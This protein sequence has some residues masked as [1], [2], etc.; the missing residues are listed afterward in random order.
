MKP[1]K[2]A[3]F[4][5]LAVLVVWGVEQGIGNF[6]Q[7]SLI[8][9]LAIFLGAAQGCVALVAAAELC[10]GKWAVPLKKHLLKAVP[11]I[12]MCAILY[13]LIIPQ[14][15]TLYPEAVTNGKSKWF[16]G[17]A[18]CVGR[19]F[20][21]M[22]ISFVFAALYSKYTL[23]G[24]SL[25]S[26][27]FAVLYLFSYVICQTFYALD[28]V[29]PL[30][31]P[32]FSTLFGA[33]FFVEGLYLGLVISACLCYGMFKQHNDKVPADVE[34]SQYDVSLLM[35][36]FSILWTYMF[37]SQFIAIWYGNIPEEVLFFSTRTFEGGVNTPI[38]FSKFLYIGFSAAILLFLIPFVSLM[39][40]RVKGNP[41][42][43]VFLGLLIVTGSIL[44]K[45]YIIGGVPIFDSHHEHFSGR[46]DLSGIAVAIEFALIASIYYLQF[47][48][49]FSEEKAA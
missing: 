30:E 42:T 15:S 39:F 33:S 46:L 28:V 9:N 7:S 3:V 13:L 12:A 24:N 10:E 31:Y 34:K 43:M 19:N 11:L 44:E 45:V 26:R 36:G 22:M 1:Q 17:L 4:I 6:H 32:W 5:G 49:G 38:Y 40:K 23:A 16:T 47:K 37:F 20:A 41:K 35:H 2:L 18:F 29:M 8:F 48:T 14:W 21:I 27:R 25:V